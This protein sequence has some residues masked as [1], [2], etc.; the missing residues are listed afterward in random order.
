[1][2]LCE[3]DFDESGSVSTRPLPAM[4]FDG[5]RRRR[6]GGDVDEVTR[7]EDVDDEENEV[8]L[9]S[10]LLVEGGGRGRM[11]LPTIGGRFSLRVFLSY[12]TPE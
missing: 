2:E 1:M 3:D 6:Y 12:T 7:A 4:L 5:T 10:S 11:L 9:S 8:E